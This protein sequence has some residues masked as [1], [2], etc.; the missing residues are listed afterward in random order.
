MLS[1]E[2]LG[3]PHCDHPQPQ[4][5]G[6]IFLSPFLSR[7]HLDSHHSLVSPCRYMTQLKNDQL[8]MLK[9]LDELRSE[10]DKFITLGDL[11][12]V[13][14]RACRELTGVSPC[15]QSSLSRL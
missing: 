6:F 4:N 10:V 7:P 15:I 1:R 2:R 8:Q 3:H 13:S 11:K 9:D 12:L 5:A 14:S